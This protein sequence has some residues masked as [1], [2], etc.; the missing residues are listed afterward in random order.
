MKKEKRHPTIGNNVLIGAGAIVL[1][2]ITIGD[3]VRIGSGSVVIKSVPPESTV[4]GTIGRVVKDGDR[5]AMNLEHG[6]LPDPI[7]EA[8]K[9][10]LWRQNRCEDRLEKLEYFS[11]I[12]I[13]KDDLVEAER[14]IKSELGQGEGI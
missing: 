12:E 10:V 11:G 6:K 14:K 2:A 13:H 9:L 3:G 4:V 8:I 7:A 1:G 5:P